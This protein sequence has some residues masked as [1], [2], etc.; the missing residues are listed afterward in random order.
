MTESLQHRALVNLLKEHFRKLDDP[1][2]HVEFS[3]EPDYLGSNK[4]PLIGGYRPDVVWKTPFN[5]YRF[6]G[7]AKTGN[8]IDNNHSRAQFEA[9]LN[10]LHYDGDNGQL[11]VAVPWGAENTASALLHSLAVKN[12]ISTL[13]YSI[14]STA[15]S[16]KH[17]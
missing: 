10:A 2:T 1:L 7:E 6:I 8:D 13:R 16:K 17:G 14:I 3:D 15:P 11:V 5:R 12:E 4:P 9:Y